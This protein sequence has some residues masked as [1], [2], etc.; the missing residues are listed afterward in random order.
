MNREMSKVLARWAK[1]NPTNRAS[2]N[3]WLDETIAEIANGKGNHIVSSSGNGI[4]VTFNSNTTNSDW[5]ET[6]SEALRILDNGSTNT[7]TIGRIA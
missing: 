7:K 2:L 4:S 6:L 3:T 1:S 5:A